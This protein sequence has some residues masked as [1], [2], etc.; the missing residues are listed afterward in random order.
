MS[1]CRDKARE[2]EDVAVTFAEL[3]VNLDCLVLKC[4]RI[5]QS[6]VISFSVSFQ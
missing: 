3:Y 4:A 2:N 6:Y 5:S 1:V